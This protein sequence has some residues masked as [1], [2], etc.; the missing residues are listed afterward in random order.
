M[1]A[2]SAPRPRAKPA[3][4]RGLPPRVDRDNGPIHHAGVLAALIGGAPSWLVSM[5]VHMG[6]LLVLALWIVPP[7]PEQDTMGMAI[8]PVEIEPE[9][10]CPGPPEIDPPGPIVA[11]V[12]DPLPVVDPDD[13]DPNDALP[14]EE[15]SDDVA[16]VD[17]ARHGWAAEDILARATG[18]EGGGLGL[19]TGP[20]RRG[21]PGV[22]GP[23][24]AAVARA[25]KWLAA[26]QRHDGGWGF[27]HAS[28]SKC[29]GQCRNAGA[30]A[31]AR[32]AAT[33]LALLP[34]LG[35][36]HTHKTGDYKRTVRAGLYFLV[37]RMRID[38]RG[39]SLHEP[40]GRMYSHGIAAI[41]LCEAFAMTRD[42]SLCQPA[43]QA[44][45]F[46]AYAQDPVGGG[47]RYEVRQPG[48]T[49]VV[50]WQIM[51]L[52]SGHLAYLLVPPATVK[53]AFHF[54]DTVQA[55]SGTNYGYTDP[56]AG[57]AT[58]AIGLLCRMHLGWSRDNP[59]LARG[60][61]WIARQGPSPGDMYY[62]YYAS[63]VMHHFGGESGEAWNG[64]LRDQLIASQA[65]QGH[66]TG[67]WFMPGG[68]HGSRQGG[69]LYCTS[70]ATMVLE[71]PYRHMRIYD[72]AGVEAPFPD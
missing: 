52:K 50:G 65:G 23:S 26:H 60:V 13:V 71:V 16:L 46:I 2:P 35:A 64:K 61:A 72:T 15:P 62:N 39:G 17:L 40:G 25:L 43:Q 33:G 57:K 6:I 42:R 66:E 32:V 29:R 56:G 3:P 48:D 69:R 31:E 51:A 41:A 14:P 11:M 34:F 9:L 20:A 53:K 24:E 22:T 28:C 49:S 8:L 7:A 36:G 4:A 45:R 67:S 47:W 68:D 1:A 70:M 63:Q 5:V 58:T 27:D 37:A 59:S 55:N 21:L 54:L 44:L 18:P 30:M 10:P 38:Q 12:T 19:R